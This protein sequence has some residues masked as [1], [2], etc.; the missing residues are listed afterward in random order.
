MFA[1]LSR[2]IE[3]TETL[4]KIPEEGEEVEFSTFLF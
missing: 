3:T 1:D 2:F 4:M